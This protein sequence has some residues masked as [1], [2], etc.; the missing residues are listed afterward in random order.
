MPAGDV[1]NEL[2]DDLADRAAEQLLGVPRA[3]RAAVLA[4]LIAQYPK[5]A[6]GLRRLH[7]DLEVTARKNS[8][9]RSA[10]A[11]AF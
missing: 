2:P 9:S 10:K 8:S 3:E 5:Q 11:K 1:M 4:T 6:T 7:R